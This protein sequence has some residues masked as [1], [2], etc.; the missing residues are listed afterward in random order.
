MLLHPFLTAHNKQLHNR[1]P[2]LNKPDGLRERGGDVIAAAK[3]LQI[4]FYVLVVRDCWH[5]AFAVGFAA[6]C[7][8]PAQ[9]SLA[10][11][12]TAFLPTAR[13]TIIRVYGYI[14]WK[15][16]LMTPSQ[17]TVKRSTSVR[18]A[19]HAACV[20]A[21][22][23]RGAAAAAAGDARSSRTAR[24]TGATRGK[25]GVRGMGSGGLGRMGRGLVGCGRGTC[26]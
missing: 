19:S 2:R 22:T 11:N 25:R 17:P 7:L 14:K 15:R 18:Q 3:P 1:K 4:I 8:L 24:Q 20:S 21:V 23:T 16:Y 9:R 10:A 6:V 26:S 13:Y 12:H 5:A